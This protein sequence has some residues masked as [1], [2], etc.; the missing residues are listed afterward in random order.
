MRCPSQTGS[1][2]VA[3]RHGD[4]PFAQPDEQAWPQGRPHAK[5]PDACGTVKAS[6]A[7]QGL[8]DEGQLRHQ[9]A[10]RESDRGDAFKGL[11][12]VLRSLRCREIGERGQR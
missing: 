4:G 12:Q 6:G 8:F 11:L 5:S 2:V 1:R 10:K 7:W 9:A 3:K